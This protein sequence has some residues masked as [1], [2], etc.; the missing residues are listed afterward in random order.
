M[1]EKIPEVTASPLPDDEI[2]ETPKTTEP[3]VSVKP[4][5]TMK[6]T[7][8]EVAE[9]LTPYQTGNVVLYKGDAE[10]Y[11]TMMGEKYICGLCNY[12]TGN[13]FEEVY[14]LS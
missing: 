8:G 10:K 11:F 6:P 3:T 7:E 14:N 12:K 4:T 9:Y 1:R 2:W 13:S 5:S